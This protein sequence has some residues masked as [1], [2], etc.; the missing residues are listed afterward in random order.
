[1]DAWRELGVTPDTPLDDV[2]RAWRAAARETHPDRGGDPAVFNRKRTA[3]ESLRGRASQE[4]SAAPEPPRSWDRARAINR[5]VD[6]DL[7]VEVIDDVTGATGR[8]AVA[9]FGDD[10]LEVEGWEVAWADVDDHVMWSVFD[11]AGAAQAA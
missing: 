3:W 6:L 5:A 4:P 10:G 9:W 1:M 7:Y 2:R 11:L 8:G